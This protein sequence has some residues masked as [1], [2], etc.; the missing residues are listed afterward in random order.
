MRLAQIEHAYSTIA[1]GTFAEALGL[2]AA[3]ERV[4]MFLVNAQWTLDDDHY[5][6][7]QA[8]DAFSAFLVSQY[9]EE[10]F[11]A[12]QENVEHMTS[13]KTQNDASNTQQDENAA[14]S[15]MLQ[16][17]VKYAELLDRT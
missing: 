8:S 12:W 11:G 2:N 15:D 7:P 14:K 16:R 3:D 13:D 1:I 4:Q 6:H 9:D 5:V 17:L 10:E